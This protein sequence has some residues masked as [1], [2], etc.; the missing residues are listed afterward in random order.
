MIIV[1]TGGEM[2]LVNERT[3]RLFGYD[4]IELLGECVDVLL[5]ESVRAPHGAHR[6][7]YSGNP[8]TRGMGARSPM[9]AQRRDGSIFTVEIALNPLATP[10]GIL[11]STAIREV[12]EAQTAD[13]DASHFRAVVQSSRDA[14]IGTTL[15]GVVTS[16]NAGAERLYGYLAAEML[17]SPIAMLLPAGHDDELPEVL[18]QFQRGEP[19]D[20]FETVRR[21]KDA[22]IVEVSMT[23]SPIADAAG[24]LIGTSTIARDIAARVRYRQHLQFLAEHDELTGAG[25]RRR[26]ALDISTQLGRAQRYGEPA[27]LLVIDMDG[28]KQINDRFGHLA[29]DEALKAV[30]AALRGRLRQTDTLARV[31]GDEFAV[32]LPRANARQSAV[33]AAS[34]RR[35][36]S[37]CGIEAAGDYQIRLSASIGA[38]QIDQSTPSEQDVFAAADRAMYADKAAHGGDGAKSAL[39]ALDGQLDP[40]IVSAPHPAVACERSDAPAPSVGPMTVLLV[41]DE[42]ALRRLVAMMLEEQGYA[43]LAAADGLEAVALAESHSGPLHMLVTDVV[44]P[45]LGGPELAQRLRDKRPGLQILFMSGYNDSRLLSRGVER[46]AVN[47]LLKPFSPDQLI[48]SLAELSMPRPA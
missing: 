13:R 45:G 26:F 28:F 2:V 7:G 46:A 12:S 35:V 16:W 30:A 40:D 27:G 43:V 39:A 23:I 20:D 22:T 41:E 44:M 9:P 6:A 42:P 19:V 24:V 36:I 29:G 31:G 37:E 47:L 5:P 48:D 11:V 4:R 17:G 33:V 14:I 18:R 25:N 38:V 15:D 34:L 21:R 1:G 8:Q 10:D 3:E 32:L